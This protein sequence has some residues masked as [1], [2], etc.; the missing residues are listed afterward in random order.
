VKT[1]SKRKPN[2]FI[3][4]QRAEKKTISSLLK[5][6]L[7]KRATLFP[8]RGEKLCVSNKHGV[9]LILD[10]SDRVLHVGRTH[11]GA[12]GLWQR[13]NNHLNGQSSFVHTF[14]EEDKGQ[15]R[16][17]YKYKYIEVG[18]PRRR[19]LLEHLATGVL[20]PAHLGLGKSLE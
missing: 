14:L 9:Y 1:Q 17:R 8:K 12:R 4:R 19:A 2:T 5:Q 16:N 20:C 3:V 13:L 7:K 6:L 15:L 10:G 11:R 18:W